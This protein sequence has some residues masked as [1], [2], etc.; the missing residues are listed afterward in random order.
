MDLD[1][2]DVRRIAAKEFL[3]ALDQLQ[4]S[5][6]ALDSQPAASK[7]SSVANSVANATNTASCHRPTRPA[8]PTGVPDSRGKASKSGG[9]RFTLRD[10]EMAIA[11]IDNYMQARHSSSAKASEEDQG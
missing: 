11:D 9:S 5:L 7:S 2:R 4:E 6:Q 10:L 1:Q 3:D 8:S